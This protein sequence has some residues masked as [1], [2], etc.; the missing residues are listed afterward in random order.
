L[1][2]IITQY[3]AIFSDES[4]QN[5][6]I[7][8]GSI[9]F[10]WMSEIIGNYLSILERDLPHINEGLSLQYL[11]D[12]CMYYGV[13]MGRVGVDFRGSSHIFSL[14]TSAGLLLP[15]FESCILNL[16][17]SGLS[18]STLHFVETLRTYKFMASTSRNYNMIAIGTKICFVTYCIEN[19]DQIL[20]PQELLDH[21][22]IAVLANGYL[23]TLNELRY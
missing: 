14:V 21:P 9:L 6:P 17:N 18:G 23:A 10:G 16:Y 11:L 22:L 7:E 4:S 20:P 5:D 2:D 13:S 19:R 8:Y 12:Q 15:L 3:R 1:F